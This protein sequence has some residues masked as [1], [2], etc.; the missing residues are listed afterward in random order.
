MTRICHA[1]GG[2]STAH[3]VFEPGRGLGVP[4]GLRETGMQESDLDTACEI[5]MSSRASTGLQARLS[6]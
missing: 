2:G 1:P 5:A 3:G 4:S 6:S